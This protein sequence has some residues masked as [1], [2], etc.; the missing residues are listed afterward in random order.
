MDASDGQDTRYWTGAH[1]KHCLRYHL[2]W[3]PK[4]RRR[5]LTGGIAQRLQELLH[6]ACFVNRWHIQELAIQPDH[7]H[8]LLQIHASDSLKDVMQRLKGGTSR[9][10]RAEF[11]DLDEFLWGNSFW[12][13]GYFAET[14]GTT[15]EHV[16]RRYIR[17]QGSDRSM[18]DVL[19]SL[20]DE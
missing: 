19:P 7:V 4:Y 15:E 9:M 1:T 10:L 5:L 17:D 2:V 8:L 12:A 20:F 3:I 6:Q 18:T 14:V 11:P 13:Q 16:I